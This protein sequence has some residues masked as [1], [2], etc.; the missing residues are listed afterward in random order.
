[1]ECLG[2]AIPHTRDTL[3]FEAYRS[4]MLSQ[5]LLHFEEGNLM[6]K[7]LYLWVA[8]KFMFTARK[9]LCQSSM[10]RVTINPSMIV[11]IIA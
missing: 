11:E 6:R 2:Q 4:A 1:M 7:A 9:Q 5:N 3:P 8:C 10:M